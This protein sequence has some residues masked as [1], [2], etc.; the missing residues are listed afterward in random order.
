MEQLLSC[1]KVFLT[2]RIGADSGKSVRKKHKINQFY[3][4]PTAIR[5]LAKEDIEK[6]I[7]EYDLSYIKSTWVRWRAD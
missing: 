5:A 7:E 2:I 3:T 4:A 1:S 6:Y